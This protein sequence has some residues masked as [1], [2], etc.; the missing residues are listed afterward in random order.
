MLHRLLQKPDT[1]SGN[2]GN[3]RNMMEKPGKTGRTA[4]PT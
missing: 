1:R 3:R 4:I 2:G